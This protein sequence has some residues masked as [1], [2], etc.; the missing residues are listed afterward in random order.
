[1]FVVGVLVGLAVG[2]PVGLL[3]GLPV[4][5]LVGDPV[6]LPVGDSVGLDVGMLGLFVVGL[7]VGDS[8]G[9]L[10]GLS[11]STKANKDLSSHKFDG[12]LSQG[13]RDSPLRARKL[14]F[15]CLHPLTEK[16]LSTYSAS[17]QLSLVQKAW[18]RPHADPL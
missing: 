14:C 12:T 5:L 6:G 17:S 16:V 11:V 18:Q 3:V 4:G 13:S 8:V 9:M 7:F 10:V 1:M 15:M 2:V